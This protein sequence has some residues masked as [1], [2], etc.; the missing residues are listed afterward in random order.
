MH[1]LFYSRSINYCR[2]FTEMAETYLETI[3]YGSMS[4]NNHYAIKSLDFALMC[5]G[6]HDY[7]VRK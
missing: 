2:I 6:H 7:E 5:V 4:G 3:V 1:N